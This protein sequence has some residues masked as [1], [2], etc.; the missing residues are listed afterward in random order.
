MEGRQ[1]FFFFFLDFLVVHRPGGTCLL[2]DEIHF[3][4]CRHMRAYIKMVAS[5]PLAAF[6]LS[7]LVLK[8]EV[9]F[10]KK[11]NFYTFNYNI[12]F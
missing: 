1:L 6:F 5:V 3:T 10:L 2:V 12:I 4:C 9:Y 11:N 7:I 8:R